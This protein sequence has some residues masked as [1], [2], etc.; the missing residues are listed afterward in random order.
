MRKITKALIGVVAALH[1]YFAW[2]EMFA[3][4]TRGPEVFKAFPADLF[5]QTT[6][7]AANQ[8]LYNAFLGAGLVWAL[9]IKDKRWSDNVA[10]CFL[11]FVVVA[12]VFGA[13]TVSRS[14]LVVQ[15]VP[16]GIALLMLF[17]GRER[18]NL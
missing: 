10:A 11:I 5:A 4:T 18:R 2:F 17:F 16:A 12:G 6:A 3:W 9:L 7:M 8:G 15:A 13:L 1:F 14:I